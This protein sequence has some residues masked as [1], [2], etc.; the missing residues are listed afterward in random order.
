MRQEILNLLM[1][2]E[3]INAGTLQEFDYNN[4]YGECEWRQ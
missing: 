3:I 4:E 1:E 2:T